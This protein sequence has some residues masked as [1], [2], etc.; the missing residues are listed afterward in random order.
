[1]VDEN[2][3]VFVLD[4]SEKDYDEIT[5]PFIVIPPGPGGIEAEGDSITLEVEAGMA[6]WKQQGVSLSVPL[7]VIAE[8]INFGKE[9]NWY[10]GVGKSAMGITKQ[11]LQAFGI[12]DKVIKRAKGKIGIV[13]SGFAGAKAVATFRRELSNKGNLRSV[14]DSTKF[15]PVGSVSTPS[16]EESLT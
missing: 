13:P 2:E 12:E 5:S 3:R 11:G 15:Y 10:A 1:M 8:G 6:D 9:A 16:D 4:V 14:L 7:T